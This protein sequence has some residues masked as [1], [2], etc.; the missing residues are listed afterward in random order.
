MKILGENDEVIASEVTVGTHHVFLIVVGNIHFTSEYRLERLQSFSLSLLVDTISVV[1]KFLDAKHI[2]VVSDGHTL[3]SVGNGFVNEF[4]YWRH[5]VEDGG[6]CV[7]V[8]MYE[9]LHFSCFVRL[10]VK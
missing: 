6:A 8:E 9:V 4:S 2:A 10:S 1:E 3:H 7:Y 5:A